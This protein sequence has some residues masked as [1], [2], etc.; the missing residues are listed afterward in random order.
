MTWRSLLALVA[1]WIGFTLLPVALATQERTAAAPTRVAV[2][3]I[4]HDELPLDSGQAFAERMARR[5][6][7]RKLSQEAWQTRKS[8][9]GC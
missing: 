1:I 4:V 3:P 5:S 2:T 7:V 8:V 6:D 9:S